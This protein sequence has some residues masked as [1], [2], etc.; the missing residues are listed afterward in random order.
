MAPVVIT[1]SSES[2]AMRIMTIA[3]TQSWV[4]LSGQQEE[5]LENQAPR[6]TGKSNNNDLRK[7]SQ[8]RRPPFKLRL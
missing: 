2:S 4:D 5:I 6:S 1:D 3:A 7:S 8:F